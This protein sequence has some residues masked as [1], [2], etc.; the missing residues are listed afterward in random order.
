MKKL[1]RSLTVVSPGSPFHLQELDVL[2]EGGMVKAMS[3]LLQI[4]DAEEVCFNRKTYIA[5][6]FFDLHVHFGQPGNETAETIATGCAA[7]LAGGFT[8]VLVMPSTQPALDKRQSAAFVLSQQPKHAPRLFVAGCI[9]EGRKGEE[10]AELYDLTLGGAA[11]FTDHPRSLQHAGLLVRALQYAKPLGKPIMQVADTP[12]LYGSGFVNES[13]HSVTYGLKGIPSEAEAIG[14]ARDLA[15]AEYAQTP[16]HFSCISA[17]ASVEL[18][19]QAKAKGQPVTC[20][21]CVHNL[22]FSEEETASFDTNFKVKPPLRDK[23]TITD[24][25]HALADGTIDAVSSNHNPCTL[26]DKR[27]E[28]DHASFGAAGLE[29]FFGQFNSIARKMISVE[30]M[31]EVLSINPR[32][33]LSLPI[34]VVAIGASAEFVIFNTDETYIFSKQHIKSIS[35]N[36]P[37]LGRQLVG[38]IEE[39]V[40]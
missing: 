14:I 8:G 23:A 24:L 17:S 16:I 34:P 21:V 1:Y 26:E 3:N 9:S 18:I 37:A 10:L 30:R 13:L 2:I 38:R 28:F 32:K 29:S 40:A 25:I 33:I 7:A 5:P 15:L 36:Y 11:A 12:S 31:M 4:E 39:V 22:F 20:D 35:E 19:R 6:G 27:Q